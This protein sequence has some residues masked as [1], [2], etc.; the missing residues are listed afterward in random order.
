MQNRI[1]AGLPKGFKSLDEVQ[2]L[3]SVFQK[4]MAASGNPHARLAIRGSAVTNRSFDNKTGKYIGHKFDD[5][6][7][8]SDFDF[9]IVDGA[10]F[11]RA[12]RA[13]VD[14]APAGTRT[15]PLGIDD[16]RK[17]GLGSMA[18]SMKRVVGERDHNFVVYGSE[19]AIVDRGPLVW[20]SGGK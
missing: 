13:G 15:M 16:L 20:L 17:V 5:G 9:A 18:E 19:K 8:Q 12:I 14:V 3:A 1:S 11:N 6:K 4:M 10:L 7:K 2:S